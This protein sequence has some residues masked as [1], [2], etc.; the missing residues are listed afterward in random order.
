QDTS[1]RI[2]SSRVDKTL[3]TRRDAIW[4]GLAIAGTAAVSQFDERIERWSQTSSVQGGS[5]RRNLVDKLT[6][7][8][9]T[10]L[11]IAAILTYGAGRLGHWSTVTDIGL[12]TTEAMLTTDA[13]SELIRGPV[14]RVRPRLSPNDAFKFEFG[15]GFT[16]F[17]NRAF[18]SLHAASA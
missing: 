3:F 4:T 16:D 17:S 6:H 15:K 13:V 2:D 9:E 14:G 5:S 10:P 12:H 8:N 11:T 1:A 18:P 7:V